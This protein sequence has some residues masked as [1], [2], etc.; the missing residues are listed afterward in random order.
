MEWSE[1]DRKF[2]RCQKY[3]KVYTLILHRSA[4]L[5][6]QDTEDKPQ[7]IDLAKI[8]SCH[9]V[10]SYQAAAV[11]V[12]SRGRLFPFKMETSWRLDLT[13]QRHQRSPFRTNGSHLYLR[14]I[15]RSHTTSVRVL[16][17]DT[18]TPPFRYRNRRARHRNPGPKD[19]E[20]RTQ[21]T[22]N[23]VSRTVEPVSVVLLSFR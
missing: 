9:T 10:I 7:M 2:R 22:T 20:W 1:C 12:M 14:V 18:E 5:Y 6:S 21:P 17:C 23:C 11:P 3:L 8:V 16:P 13:R 19:T 4:N 15:S